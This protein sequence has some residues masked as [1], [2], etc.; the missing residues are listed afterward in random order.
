[1]W[2]P[3]LFNGKDRLF[4]MSNYEVVPAAPAGVRR[5]YDLPS[6]AMRTGNFSELL[7]RADLRSR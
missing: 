5:L 1:M 4:F 7:T 6:A 3:K 2:I